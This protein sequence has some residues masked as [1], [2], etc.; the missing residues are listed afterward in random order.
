MKKYILFTCLAF[1]YFS[2]NGLAQSENRFIIGIDPLKT[3]MHLI[4]G[5]YY[6]SPELNYRFSKGLAL[7]LESTWVDAQHKS[8]E[9]NIGSY[10]A[11]GSAQKIGI[12]WLAIKKEPEQVSLG[13]KLLR[14]Q[15]QER[16][17]FEIPGPY[18][19]D[20]R[21]DFE[22]EKIQTLGIELELGYLVELLPKFWIKVAGSYANTLNS[23]VLRESYERG[24]DRMG[25]RYVPGFGRI[26][27]P[28]FTTS[29]GAFAFHSKVFYEF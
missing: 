1:V 24:L 6:F 14:S 7:S 23:V 22:R 9:R 28:D 25:I 21:E 15:F 29:I 17:T 13:I 11:K 5:G 20:Y 10:Y 12:H 26:V 8:E 19:G 3:A 18:F 27:F 4:G 2:M 16:G